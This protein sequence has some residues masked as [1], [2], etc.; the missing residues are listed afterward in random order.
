MLRALRLPIRRINY[1][2]SSDSEPKLENE[3]RGVVVRSL[4]KFLPKDDLIRSLTNTFKSTNI[5]LKTDILGHPAYALVRYD[6]EKDVRT[7]L[8]L[9]KSPIEGKRVYVNVNPM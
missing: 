6:E 9:N 7:A 2:M 4:P 5:E 3:T 8:S 1:Y